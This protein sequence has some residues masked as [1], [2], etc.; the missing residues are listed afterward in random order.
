MNMPL[1]RISVPDHLPPTQVK[2]LSEAVHR[3]LVETCAV[4]EKDLFHLITRYPRDS[5]IIDPTYP[6]F[7]RTADAS[8]V[9]ILFLLGRSKDQKA[10][11]FA[12]IADRAEL[13]GFKRDDILIA[14]TENAPSDWSAGGGQAFG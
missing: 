1:A 4:P 12:A 6:H 8:I 5:M 9:E 2:G 10:R 14:L 13:I 7:E 3:G 11:L